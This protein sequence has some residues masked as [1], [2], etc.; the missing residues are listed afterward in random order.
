[1]EALRRRRR[2]KQPVTYLRAL[3]GAALAL[4]TALPTDPQGIAALLHVIVDRA[5]A[6]VGARD[7]RLVLAEEAAWHDVVPGSVAVEGHVVLDHRGRLF[8]APLRAGGATAH[9][10]AT[11]EVVVV[12]DTAA[13]DRFGPYPQ[14]ARPGVRSF[15]IVPL[16]AG[17]AVLGALGVSFNEPGAW[18][19]ERREIIELFAGHAAA[20][21]ERVRLIYAERRRVEQAQ[22]LAA[23][24]AD[25]GAAP[26]VDAAVTALLHGAIRLLQGDEGV[27]QLF[28]PE[29]GVR[30][31][32][33]RMDREGTIV[34]RSTSPIIQAG[35]YAAALRA[36]APPTIVEDY[37]ALD[38][39]RYPLYESLRERGIRSSVNVP[40]DAGGQRIGTLHVNHRQPGFFGPADLALAEALAIQ[41]GAVIQR[42]RLEE[43]GLRAV[44]ARE[45]ALR[46]LARRNAAL[47]ASKAEASELR[48]VDALKDEFFSTVVHELRTPLT[49]LQGYIQHL[50]GRA[51]PGALPPEDLERITGTMLMAARQL[52]RLIDDLLDFSRIER[53]EIDVQLEDVDLVPMLDGVASGFRERPGGERVVAV[54]PEHLYA[55]ADRT[56]V[57]QVLGNL[58]DNAL[59]YAPHG[60][61]EIGAAAAGGV[62]RV[63]VQDRGPG[64]PLGEQIL[65]W[66]KFQRGVSA[67]GAGTAE[68]TGIGLAVVQALVA[69]QG[70]RVGL[71]SEP[72]RG[73]RFWFELPGSAEA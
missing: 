7:G 57:A 49:V 30:R 6:A 70:G 17:G 32:M 8:R 24:L 52:G 40:V 26:D 43:A 63:W 3:H 36:G 68:G 27:L 51:R 54:L 22:R 58:V 19:T 33:L 34:A 15:V 23:T 46:E 61:V 13:A 50:R 16:A 56:R 41:A 48:Q 45:A 62:A 37:A 2:P 4:E 12:Q 25:V 65:I 71:E 28:D 60:L 31:L 53:G 72:G 47:D 73:A 18:Q 29:R 69:A 67:S 35:S 9:V 39:Q 1:M 20:A 64:I 14:L 5:V 10:L 44:E 59:K 11:G 42:A 21:L 66:Q 38:P 55:R